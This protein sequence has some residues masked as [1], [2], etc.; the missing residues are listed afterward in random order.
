MAVDKNYIKECKLENVYKRM[1]QINEYV[2]TNGR[3]SEAAEMPQ[4]DNGM[5]PNAMPQGG[6][7]QGNGQEQMPPAGGDTGM[8]QP[9]MGGEQMPQGQDGLETPAQPDPTI[10]A[11]VED[12]PTDEPMVD[13]IEMDDETMAGP[14]DEVIDVD[15]LTNSQESTEYKIDGVDDKLSKLLSIVGKFANAIEANDAKLEDLKAEIERRNP[16]DIERINLRSQNSQPFNVNPGEYWSE[17]KDKNPNYQIISDNEVSPNDE[18]KVY[19]ITDDDL[20]DFNTS[21][22]EKSFSDFPSD[23][24]SY[25][26]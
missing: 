23:L 9:D 7:T 13:G 19:T 2:I 17:V 10:G 12:T 14:D 24:L 8:Q 5:D 22:V 4:D 15:D 6:D 1:R 26:K 21:E 3:T 11:D 18:D 16:T 25:F 20:R